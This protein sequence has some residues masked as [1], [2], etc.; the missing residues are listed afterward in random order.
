M[1]ILHH[2]KSWAKAEV[3]SSRF[4]ILFS[5]AFF[6]YSFWCYFNG[7]TAMASAY[8]LPMI[9]TGSFLLA[10]G[11]GIYIANKRRVTSFEKDYHADKYAFIQSELVRTKKS[12]VEYRTVV[13]IAIPILIAIASVLVYYIEHPTLRSSCISFIAMAL[14]ILLVDSQANARL[15]NYHAQLTSEIKK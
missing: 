1:D 3:F 11:I 13:F 5:V 6:L 9:L 8:V 7:T 12:L 10:A 15:E 4:F 14:V 2:A